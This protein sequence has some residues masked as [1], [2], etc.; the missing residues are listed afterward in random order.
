M[1]I[2]SEPKSLIMYGHELR[3]IVANDVRLN[4]QFLGVFAANELPYQMPFGSLAIVN[5]CNRENPGRHWVVIH[6]ATS[7]RLEMFD[8]Y[9]LSPT[10][11][12]LENKLPVSNVVVYNTKQLQSIHS[13]VCGYYCLY[14]CYFKSRGYAMGDIVSIFSNDYTSND[15]YVYNSVLHLFNMRR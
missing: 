9:G 12:N 15:M 13:D 5:C 2:N 1:T 10:M 14:Y 3:A 11:Y 7:N 4:Q 8:S 6:Q